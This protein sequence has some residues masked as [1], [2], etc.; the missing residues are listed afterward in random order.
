[1]AGLSDKKGRAAAGRWWPR[2]R[3]SS[4]TGRRRYRRLADN[5]EPLESRRL[6]ATLVGHW[7]ADSLQ[8]TTPDGEAVASWLDGVSGV[9]ATAAGQPRLIASQYMEHAVV[10]FDP[11][12]GVDNFR[13][14]ADVS[15]MSGAQDFTVAVVLAT[16]AAGQDGAD[17]WYNN[18]GIVDADQPVDSGDWGIAINGAGQIAAGLGRSAR[19]VYSTQTALH[20]GRLHVAVYTR[21][22]GSM[23]LYVDGQQAGRERNGDSFPRD[24]TD[25]TFGSLQTDANYFAGDI[26]E[27]RIYDD[28]LTAT[29][30]EQLNAQLS[31]LYSNHPPSAADDQLQVPEDGTLILNAG[32]GVL[33]NDS[34]AEG[35]AL[36]AILVEPVRHGSLSLIDSGAVVYV[37]QANFFGT[38]TFSYQARD[39]QPS[40]VATVTIQVLP[41]NVDPAQA[42]ADRYVVPPGVEFTVDA[43]DGVLANDVNPEQAALAAVLVEDV[44]QGT[45]ALGDDGAFTYDAGTLVGAT[46]FR[47]AVRD[48]LGQQNTVTV[49]LVANA[50]PL[51]QD[52]NYELLEDQ[53]LHV[54]ASRGVLANDVDAESDP[55]TVTLMDPPG[56][57]S[58]QL[59]PD[60]SI[61]YEP[62]PEYSGP[63]SFAYAVHDGLH[64]SAPATVQ[65][66]VNTVDDPPTANPDVYFLRVHRPISVAADAGL[67]ANDLDFDS[68]VVSAVLQSGP[69]HGQLQL[70]PDGSFAYQPDDAFRGVD[71][72]AYTAGDGVGR[73]EPVSVSLVVSDLDQPVV[74]NEIHYDTMDNTQ[75]AEFVELFNAGSEPVDVS[76]WQFSDGIEYTIPGGT[77]MP[78]HGCL[79][80]GEDPATLLADFGV[81]ALGPFQGGLSNDGERIALENAQGDLIDEVEYGV[82]YPWPVASLGEG[83]SLELILPSLDDDLGGSWRAEGP[84]TPGARNSAFALNAPPQSR[85]VDHEPQDPRSGQP[86]TVTLKVTDPDGVQD[87]QL[88]YQI[89][90]PG[91]YIPAWL[92]LPMNQL[93]AAR[94]PVPAMSPNPQYHD[95]ANWTSVVMVDDGSGGDVAAGDGVYTA[96]IPGQ[97]HRTLVRYR[98]TLSDTLGASVT[99][100]YADDTSLNFAYFVY[101]GVPEYNGHSTEV[102]ESL[103]V[104]HFIMRG[105]DMEEVL[106]YNGAD[107]M[108]QGIPAWWAYNWA[109]T[110][111]YEGQVYD[112]IHYRLRGANGRYHVRGKRSMKF[113]FNKGHDFQAYDQAGDPYP[114]KWRFLTTGKGFDNRQTLTYGLNE[115]V[116]YYLFDQVGVPSPKTHWFHFRVID[117]AEE[118]DQY[119]GDFWGLNFAIETYDV[120]FLEARPDEMEKGNLYRLINSL[121]GALDQQSYQVPYAV[122]DGSDH[123]NIE[124]NLDG[125]D[126]PAYI[127][128]VVNLP[129]YYSYLAIVE[130]VRHYDYWPD[131]NKNMAYYFEPDYRPE[132]NNLGKLWILPWDVDATWG[133]T[134]NEGDDVVYNAIFPSSAAGGD[135]NS[136]PELW[137]DYYSVLRE[138]RDLIWQ[139]DQIEPLVDYFAAQIAGF[140]PADRDRWY[141][142]PSSAAATAGSYNG[143]SGK[144]MQ[145]LDALV[146]DMK[147]FA[148]VGGTW[149]GGNVGAGGRAADLDRMLRDD[150]RSTPLKPTVAY[151]GAE[152]FALDDLRF[153]A[154]PFSDPQGDETFAAIQWRIAKV[155]DPAAPRYNPDE[156]LLEW[157]AAWESDPASSE[158]TA[159]IP[160]AVVEVGHAYRVRVK[161]MD[162]T[163]RWSH[164]SDPVQFIAPLPDDSV[165]NSLRITEIH[166]HPLDAVPELGELNADNN[167]FEFVELVNVGSLPIDLSGVRLV[168]VEVG[169]DN[170][171][172]DFAFPSQVLQPSERVV[173]V[174]NQ[175]AFQSRYGTQPSAIGQYAGKLSNEGEQLTLLAANAQVV[176]QFR[177]GVG[178]LWP[179]RANGQGSS[180]ELIDQDANPALAE[181]WRA[182]DQFGGSPGATGASD[183]TST[184]V[185]NE[186]LAHV[187]ADQDDLI[188]LYNRTSHDIDI[189]GWYLSDNDQEL[190]RYPIATPTIV[191]ALGYQSINVSQ[192]GLDL[193]GARGGRIWLTEADSAGRPRRIVMD[194]QFGASV[195]GVS[196]GRWPNGTGTFFPMPQLTLGSLNPDV[197]VG[198][199]VISEVYFSPSDPDGAQKLKAD[200]FEFVE[201]HNTTDQPVDLTGW[202]IVGSSPFDFA[203][204]TTIAAGQTLILVS[205]DPA[206]AT[207]LNVFQFLQGVPPAVIVIGPYGTLLP[208][209]TGQVRLQRPGQ[210]A[211]GDPG[212]AAR[213]WVDEVRYN[214]QTPWPAEPAGTGASLT[215]TSPSA[216][217]L[218]P[219]SWTARPASPGTVDFFLCVGGCQ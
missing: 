156:L 42:V 66:T 76:G 87:V 83:S 95:P 166:Y 117:G 173:V 140:V 162:D 164:W 192:L 36:K 189:T 160:A 195:A 163:G 11:A 86:T 180:L 165:F 127:A 6:L 22:G 45:L 73:S 148:F 93:K 169:G 34:D 217:G 183:Q 24:V 132:N 39:A 119:Q 147:N 172:I 71:S 26:A 207:K 8:A 112:N 120:R 145:G 59:A 100:P 139:P 50:A 123:D 32:T 69:A 110:M 196:L 40:N 136:N 5:F 190:L 84:P 92:P 116:S 51:A 10:R 206:N 55:L 153:Q 111:V 104:Y 168:Q 105:E 128:N 142:P 28:D 210:S 141:R 201:L 200:D 31:A 181:S 131:A 198:E 122:S 125:S 130:A 16:H 48:S 157:N 57:G 171:G 3:G 143:L 37:P 188:E 77:I 63:D 213:V 194:T 72:F 144:G 121:N 186:V 89:V 38:D 102:L 17:Q 133:P 182:S 90:L 209:A 13:V 159:H 82:G 23:T 14:A 107:Q 215:R 60:G 27:I 88:Q 96:S 212:L 219:I 68:A 12:D 19:T 41:G 176:Q 78:P 67:V 187:A 134:W 193:D 70:S 94:E 29:E 74:I 204:G 1:M 129:K 7:V 54:E 216:L 218:L 108:T 30:A 97:A 79:V 75:R 135:Q 80:V 118:T 44:A 184:L 101:D 191:P 18:T 62:D 61:A 47:Y 199:V 178:G 35:D 203:S 85:Q 124:R 138:V 175:A 115:A 98:M 177:F 58:L 126:T 151:V 106:A 158:F 20:D 33:A 197:R 21:R 53:V 211:A 150:D 154:S 52:D 179:S 152:G 149:P 185:V 103:P 174:R 81:A 202:Q 2:H 214:V 161:V 109:G 208:D 56:H 15:P 4:P 113:Q 114:T 49:T 46:S 146:Q 91:Q 43:A 99:V 155:S 205:F 65:L 137:P 25:M 170:Q 64:E 167:E 9:P